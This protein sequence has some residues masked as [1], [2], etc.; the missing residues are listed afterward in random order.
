MTVC[1]TACS[2]LNVVVSATKILRQMGGFDP[3]KETLI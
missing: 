3:L 2:W 1:K